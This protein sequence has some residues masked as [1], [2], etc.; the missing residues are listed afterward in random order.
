MFI[1]SL[2][3][4]ALSAASDV[5]KAVKHLSEL[6]KV[7][8]H[9]SAQIR[10]GERLLKTTKL[11]EQQVQKLVDESKCKVRGRCASSSLAS[12]AL[13]GANENTSTFLA[14]RDLTDASIGVSTV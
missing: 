8:L 13:T 5:Q 6:D 14:G 10:D 4:K 9:A 11:K 12:L 3:E 7:K 1:Q 2:R